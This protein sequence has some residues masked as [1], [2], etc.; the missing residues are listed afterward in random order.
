MPRSWTSQPRRAQQAA[1]EEAVRV[2]DGARLHRLG[3]DVARHHQFVAGG[4]QRHARTRAPP[5]TRSRP[6]LAAR[7]MRGRAQAFAGAPARRAAARHVFAAGGGST[8]RRAG[9]RV[10]AHACLAATAS[11]SS[12]I[13]IA[14]APG[15]TGAPVKMRAAVP[16]C[17]GC[18]AGA[19]R[20]AL[21]DR[22][23]HA[24]VGDLGAAHG[25]AVHRAVV[26]RRH[27]QRRHQVLRQHA[28]V[29]VEGATR[30]SSPPA[31]RACA[32]RAARASSRRLQRARRAV[33]SRVSLR[34]VVEAVAIVDQPLRHR[35]RVVQVQHR[36]QGRLGQRSRRVGGD[37]DDEVVVGIARGLAGRRRARP[38]SSAGC[39]A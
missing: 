6:M 27:L 16:G 10:D 17:S 2:V 18:G 39:S 1:Q 30:V 12:C 21:A 24:L 3:R 36:P 37:G 11:V 9:T 14:S 32:S 33:R 7:P 28:A 5:A 23:Q 22:Q 29:G 25:V 20:D 19:G 15:G 35:I 26:L 34:V 13:T 4:E 31:A 8:G 38:R